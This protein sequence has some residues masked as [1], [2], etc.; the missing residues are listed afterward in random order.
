MKCEQLTYRQNANTA[1]AVH[2]PSLNKKEI[3]KKTGR[4]KSN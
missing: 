1:N 2:G 4:K 3:L